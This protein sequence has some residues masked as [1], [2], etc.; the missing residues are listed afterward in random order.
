MQD[1]RTKIKIDQN[2]RGGSLGLSTVSLEITYVLQL[3]KKQMGLESPW[4]TLKIKLI[5]FFVENESGILFPGTRA[6]LGT[7]EC[8]A[9]RLVPSLRNRI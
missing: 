4:F 5:C 8:L 2:S 6:Q 1:A 3:N 9:F 7:R